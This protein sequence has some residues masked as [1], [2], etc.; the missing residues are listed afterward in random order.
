MK[1]I[2][3]TQFKNKSPAQWLKGWEFYTTR[4]NEVNIYKD[5]Y[6]LA[7]DCNLDLIVFDVYGVGA[8]LKLS[9]RQIEVMTDAEA[10]CCEK[11]LALNEREE[12]AKDYSAY[13]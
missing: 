11:Q 1:R 4:A 7:L 6:F 5:G 12:N 13:V 2:P 8:R 9:Q 3:T 10:I